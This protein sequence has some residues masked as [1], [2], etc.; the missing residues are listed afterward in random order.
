MFSNNGYISRNGAKHSIYDNDSVRKRT[1]Y[2]HLPNHTSNQ[3]RVEAKILAWALT[4]TGIISYVWA[5]FLNLKTWKADVL[6][7]LGAAFLLMKFIR[8]TIK[9]WQ[10]YRK[11]E[12]EIKAIQ[13][14]H[15]EKAPN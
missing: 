15:K 14:K 4:G 13:K 5:I 6:F 2:N 12:L 3:K 9:T 8:L 10:E 11:E 7:L 1:N